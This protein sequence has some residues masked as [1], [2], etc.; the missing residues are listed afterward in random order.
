MRMGRVEGGGGGGSSF[1]YL[2]S[3]IGGVNPGKRIDYF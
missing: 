2:V 3:V 1:V